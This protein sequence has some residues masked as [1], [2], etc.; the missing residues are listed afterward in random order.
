MASSRGYELH[1]SMF[2]RDGTA[3][4][5]IRETSDR[6][7]PVLYKT[8]IRAMCVTRIGNRENNEEREYSYR[9]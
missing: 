9:I 8:S 5:L 2:H 1:A 4:L 3:V 6:K 7:D